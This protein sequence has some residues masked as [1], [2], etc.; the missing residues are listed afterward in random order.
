MAEMAY[1]D[2]DLQIE[3]ATTGFRVDVNCPAGQA[4]CTFTLPFSELELENFLL[5]EIN[6]CA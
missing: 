3:P 4:T 1:L 5:P 6:Q 2:F